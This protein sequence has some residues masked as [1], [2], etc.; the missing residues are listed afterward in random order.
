MSGGRDGDQR[1]HGE[2][3][4][5]LRGDHAN[6]R[7]LRIVFAA[8]LDWRRLPA[9]GVTARVD[10]SGKISGTKIYRSSGYSGMDAEAMLAV[11][12]VRWKPARKKNRPV[13]SVVRV[14]IDFNTSI[15][16]KY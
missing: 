2:P 7:A 8:R 4:G 12:R 11:A 10:A 13:E 9:E 15:S 14:R 16:S 1:L 6:H 3:V 5:R